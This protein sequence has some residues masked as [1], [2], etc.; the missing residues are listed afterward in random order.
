[1]KKTIKNAAVLGLCGALATGTV[2]MALASEPGLP[3]SDNAPQTETGTQSG[4][5]SDRIGKQQVVYIKG[6][7]DGT[8]S[9]VYVVNAFDSQ[10]PGAISDQGSY[11]TVTNLTDSQ[12]LSCVD[13]EVAFDI[14]E[15]ETFRYQGD[16][17]PKTATPW[18]IEVSYKLDGN[19]TDPDELSGASGNIEM[20][21]S[22]DPNEE[23]V[24]DYADNYL[25]QITGTLE[26]DVARNITADDAM[27]A[28]SGDATQLTYMLLPG[29]SAEYAISFEA[30]DFEFDGF[31]MVGV[32]LSIA[33]DVSD[34][35]LGSAP[36][37]LSELSDAIAELNDGAGEVADGASSLE[38]GAAELASSS[39]NLSQ[40]SASVAAALDNL[41]KGAQQLSGSIDRQLI[42]GIQQLASGSSS[43]LEQLDQSV[44]L[45]E[46]Q[47]QGATSD[48]AAALY[49]QALQAFAAAPTDPAAQEAL[50]NAQ[51]LIT[52]TNVR[53]ALETARSG[54]SQIDGGIQE[55][56]DENDPD[57][58]YALSEGVRALASGADATSAGYNELR[59]GISTYVDGVFELKDGCDTL[60]SGAGDLAGGAQEL[61]DETYDI[62]Q[63]MIDSV[64]DELEEYLNPQFQTIDFAN[65]STNTYRVQFVYKTAGV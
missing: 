36:E 11:E 53:D 12:E 25:L 60:S 3:A 5:L 18:D 31:Q 62:D 48:Q 58:V 29:K 40:G 22:V 1:M 24:N 20:T 19:D 44:A 13:G 54:Y 26:N 27:F 6:E 28:Q 50:Q 47:T 34:E 59:Q 4:G 45:L 23:C 46:Q 10:T 63:K 32:P 42:P 56:I 2:G 9:G 33:L 16:L 43:Y 17:D 38:D 15:G 51:L 39:S 37:D 49:E 30:T 64:R 52:A 7:A 21:L 65:G 35:D 14:S 41:S 8:Q 61:F 57:S 55:M